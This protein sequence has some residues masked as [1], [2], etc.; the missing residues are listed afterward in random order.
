MP[1]ET[2]SYIMG[3]RIYIGNLSY[4]TTQDSLRSAFES[5]G[6]VTDVRVMTDRETGRSRGFAFVTMSTREEAFAAIATMNGSLLDGRS[7]RVNEAEERPAGAARGRFT[8]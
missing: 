1:S 4:D 3:N 5:A 8:S 7:L 6:S 2:Q